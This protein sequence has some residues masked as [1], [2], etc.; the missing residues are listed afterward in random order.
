MG[1]LQVQVNPFNPGDVTVRVWM[2][3][4]PSTGTP[5][6]ETFT[7]NSGNPLNKTWQLDPGLYSVTIS[8]NS[9]YQN[10]A[11]G[12]GEGNMIT[13]NGV[14]QYYQVLGTPA[15][16]NSIMANFGYQI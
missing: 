7:A 3:Q 14:G 11:S 9:G 10:I 5:I 15:A 4:S 13:V 6:N 1:T 12:G 16:G 2:S 8:W